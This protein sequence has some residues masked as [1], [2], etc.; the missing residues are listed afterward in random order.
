[1]RK[2]NTALGHTAGG[3]VLIRLVGEALAQLTHNDEFAARLY[4]A[5][6]E[7]TVLLP[8]VDTETARARA[9]EIEAALD[10]LAVPETHRSLYHGASVGYAARQSDE[11]PGQ[12][13]GLAIEA[14]RKRK[15]A[16]RSN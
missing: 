2:A 6:D 8:G 16:R 15:L 3:D 11:T 1:M 13:L 9:D 7:F 5:G 4:T 12:T 10:A 14:M